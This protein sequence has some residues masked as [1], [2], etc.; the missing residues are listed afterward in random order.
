MNIDNFKIAFLLTCYNRKQKTQECLESLFK[1][2]SSAEVYLVDDNSTDG[3]SEMISEEFPQ[4]NLL[5]GNGNLFW[6]RGMHLAWSEAIKNDYDFYIWLNDDVILYP[7]FFD[8]LLS[9]YLEAGDM[10]VITGIIIDV[11][12]KQVIYGGTDDKGQLIQVDNH[13]HPV[14]D[15]NGNVVLVPRQVVNKIGIMD[16]VLHHTGGDTDYGYMARKN[17]IAVMTTMHPVAEGYRNHFDRVHK[18]NTTISDR[19]KFLYS[20]F[21]DYPPMEFYLQKKHFGIFRAIAVYLYIHLVCI[22]PDCFMPKRKRQF[23]NN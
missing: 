1:V 14:H 5:H 10:S 9:C 6:T 7:S 3:T 18:W 8:E 22:I 2:V 19:L 20:P 23:I 16:P 13:M 11:D 15:M 21:G 4:V 12:T 17:G